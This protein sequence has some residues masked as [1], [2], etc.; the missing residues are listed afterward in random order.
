MLTEAQYAQLETI[1]AERDRDFP[2]NKIA[3]VEHLGFLLNDMTEALRLVSGR[4]EVCGEKC[5]RSYYSCGDCNG[6]DEDQGEDDG[7]LTF[8]QRRE[9]DARGMR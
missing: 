8:A 5:N 4:C 1:E 2:D 7:P 6:G 3:L 9:V